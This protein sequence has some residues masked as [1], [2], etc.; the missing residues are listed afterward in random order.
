MA[1]WEIKNDGYDYVSLFPVV[2]E[3]WTI[4][5]IRSFDGTRKLDE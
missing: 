5:Y 1:T 4:D 3:K 2:E